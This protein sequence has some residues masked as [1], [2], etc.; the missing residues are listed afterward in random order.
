MP[1]V[2][3]LL[4]ITRNWQPF[5]SGLF[6][7]RANFL[8]QHTRPVGHC[9]TS[10]H[11]LAG[12]VWK[13]LWAYVGSLSVAWP[14]LPLLLSY[15]SKVSQFEPNPLTMVS[16]FHPETVICRQWTAWNPIG[17]LLVKTSLAYTLANI[18]PLAEHFRSF[19]K[20]AS[21]PYKLGRIALWQ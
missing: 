11:M 12:A 13:Q 8:L 10:Y 7:N 9:L 16:G 18:R 21:S 6:A 15:H 5:A 4:A 14:L 3:E 1:R 2:F 17:L 19:S 20:G